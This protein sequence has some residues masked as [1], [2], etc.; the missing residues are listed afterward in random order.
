[1]KLRFQVLVLGFVGVLMAAMV[2]GVGIFGASRLAGAVDN[3]QIMGTALQKSQHSDMMHDAIRGDVF[4]AILGAVNQDTAQLADAQKDLQEH[5]ADF[6]KELTDLLALPISQDIKA[7]V[8]NV[9]P[10]V[11][12]YSDSAAQVQKL[13]MTDAAAAQAAM[14]E[15]Q[16]AFVELEKLMGEQGEAIERVREGLGSEAQAIV[17]LNRMQIG[18]VLVIALVLMSVAATLLS[19]QIARPM[20]HAVRI[21]EHLA[22]GDLSTPVRIEGNHE[23]QQLLKAMARMQSTFAGI[24]QRV[25]TGA[26]GVS[27]A[28][29]EI[30]Q[31]N[32]NLSNRTESQASALEQT[33]ASMEQLSATV[34]QNADNAVHAN[35]KFLL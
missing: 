18:I 21:A 33:A 19:G 31:G 11:K 7:K 8:N 32:Q 6:N 17:S 28:S 15:F 34:K 4:L 27:T 13:A 30:A 24:V 1:M 3:A 16:K 20:A 5:S 23:N 35:L 12:R 22:E 29:A 25:K 14:P 26:E 10:A 9:L 2:G